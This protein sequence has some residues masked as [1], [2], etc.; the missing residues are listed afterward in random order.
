MTREQ[1]MHGAGVP[2]DAMGVF[3]DGLDR[4]HGGPIEFLHKIGVDDAMQQAI[5]QGLLE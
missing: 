4:Q 2:E 5:R 1:M 3:L